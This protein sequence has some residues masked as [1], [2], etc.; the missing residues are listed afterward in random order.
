MESHNKGF[1]QMFTFV[2]KCRICN[3]SGLQKYLSLGAMPLANNLVEKNS[4]QSDLFF[5]LEV[6]FC[7]NCFL[8]QLSVVVDPN[9]LFSNYSYRTSISTTFKKHFE[10]MGNVVLSF[11]PDPKNCLVLDIASNDGC[12]LQEFKK[13]GFDVLGVEPAINIA[14]IAEKEGIKTITEFWGEKA[15]KKVL[16][17]KRKPRVI[18][19]TNVFAHVNDIHA[20]VGDVKKT[21]DPNG[22][23]IIEVPYALNLVE[24]N[25]FDTI[26]H[27]HLSYFLV[28]PFLTLFE[29]EGMEVFDVTN[30][31]I[32]GGSI[33]VFA[34]FPQN[35]NIK[36][37]NV[38]IDEFIEK[39]KAKN[40]YSFQTYEKFAEVVL[41]AKID[42][43]SLLLKLKKEGKKVAGY[44]AAA[45]ASTLLN[46]CGIGTGNIEFIIDDSPLKQ[47]K[48]FSGNRVPIVPSDAIEKYRPD[49]LVLFAWTIAAEL[50]KKTKGFQS[51][52]KYILPLPKPRIVSSENEL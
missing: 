15:V 38:R 10:E 12:L 35:R 34:K 22:I 41:E 26:Y 31:P 4:A 39:E 29:M 47:G 36:V 30:V 14:E 18:T 11:F 21:L 5:P 33:R 45:K 8:S 42:F 52:G 46:Y 2:Q 32:H 25:E 27:E 24:K 43:L 44:G 23:F 49:F 37:N 48:A 16:E 1:F 40:L 20:F 13:I 51:K 28:K 19:A 7:K 50:M 17:K 6:M 3:F 9:V